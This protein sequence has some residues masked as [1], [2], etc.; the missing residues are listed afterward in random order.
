MNNYIDGLEFKYIVSAPA[1][2]GRMLNYVYLAGEK[3]LKYK[4]AIRDDNLNNDIGNEW[5]IA[6]MVG[7]NIVELNQLSEGLHSVMLTDIGVKIYDVLISCGFVYK[8]EYHD[9]KTEKE[10][11]K[12]IGFKHETVNE[13][14]TIL[15]QAFVESIIFKDLCIYLNVENSEDATIEILKTKFTYEFYSELFNY[16]K[17]GKNK[18]DSLTAQTADNQMA[19]LK[20]LMMFLKFASE[21]GEYLVIH[22]NS[23]RGVRQKNI[24]EVSK[25]ISFNTKIKHNT[26]LYG[27]P[28]SGKSHYIRENICNDIKFMRRI[29]FHPD[30]SY[31]DFVGQVLPKSIESG[32]DFHISYPFV[33][34]PFTEI[35]R[36]AHKDPDN[37]YFLIIEEINRG[38][39]PAIFGDT[40][41]LL[42]RKNGVSVYPISNEEIA[43]VVYKGEYSNDVSLVSLPANLFLVAT[44]NTADQNVFT[45]DTAFK[46]R[47]TMKSIPNDI[48]KCA[49]SSSLICGKSIT[50]GSFVK[51]INKVI[52][53]FSHDT[54]GNE[55]KRLGA[56]FI[57][58][59]ELNDVSLFAEKVLMY[60]W[61]DAFKFNKERVFKTEYQT[62]E[63]LIDGFKE[64]YFDIF[65]ENIFGNLDTDNENIQSITIE[66][67]LANK[68][69]KSKELYTLFINEF[70]K[71]ELPYSLETVLDYISLKSEKG[72]KAAEIHLLPDNVKMNIKEPID[73]ANSI[74][75]KLLDNYGWSN[76]QVILQDTNQINSI[77]NAVLDS[78][79]QVNV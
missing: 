43:K 54:I 75:A 51:T 23:I 20:Q 4:P 66:D 41:Q 72:K 8:K 36:D 37:N 2:I 14:R 73:P 56:Y 45:L 15:S 11:V 57:S 34:G 68:S 79:N 25:T 74:G 12:K 77:V 21:E 48:E 64:S 13:I 46:R 22:L 26:I 63:E 24:K 61:N 70:N 42:D 29:V 30:Y 28:G 38:N 7:Q 5:G 49:Y 10:L 18:T 17:G 67:Y 62:V 59:E 52:V 60:L 27:V 78:Y 55:D 53:D 32:N 71:L 58:E 50:W 47:W 31:S 35:L 9:I 40:F 16:Y 69:E 1:Q 6:F 3:K 65:N 19:S 44:M 39:A 33:P 76:Y